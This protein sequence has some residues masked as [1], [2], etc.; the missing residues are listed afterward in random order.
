MK[1]ICP[2]HVRTTPYKHNTNHIAPSCKFP[3]KQPLF[4]HSPL[5]H[6]T[7]RDEQTMHI[8]IKTYGCSTNQADSQTIAGCLTQAGH[9]ITQ[10]ATTANIIIY[11]TCA[12]KGPTE[13]RIITTIKRTPKNKK[14][15]ITGC[16][17]LINL[18]RLC[19]ETRFNAAV[20]PAAA[21]QIVNIVNRV[22]KGEKFT[23]L[24]NALTAKPPLNLPRIQTN[25]TISIIP[26]NYGCQG[27]CAYCCVIHA[28]GHLR[29]YTINEITERMRNDLATD[30]KEFWLTSQDTACYGKDNDTNLAALLNAIASVEGN[31]KIRIGMMTPNTATLFLNQLIKAYKNEQV[32]KFVHLPVQSGDNTVLKRMQRFYTTEDFK[33][34]V[35]AFRTAFPKITLATDVICGFPG[36]TRSAFQ[37]TLKLIKEV[38]PDIVN[39]SKFFPRPRTPAAEMRDAFVDHAE[40][41]QRSTAMAQL[42]KQIGLE[43][44]QRWIGWTG[45]ALIDE[46]GKTPMSWISRNFAYKPI[47]IKASANMLGKT[48]NVQVTEA[49]PTYL[50]GTIR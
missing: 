10:T 19:R 26:I 21:P 17:P 5:P 44:N 20:G 31:Y 24:R 22:S 7:Y 4:F 46:K 36:E 43:R 1:Q 37:N 33:A 27:K 3:P 25:Q 9:T 38:K 23:D 18:E 28:R 13:N 35:K 34:T 42:A 50:A 47:V 8:F 49:F 12:V 29:S 32:F 48:V 2:K 11:N 16:L 41:K 45:E 14:T 15:I 6:L 40:I 30:T 39:V